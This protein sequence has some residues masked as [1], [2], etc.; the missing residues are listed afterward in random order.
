MHKNIG[1]K[2]SKIITINNGVDIEVLKNQSN[3]RTLLGNNMQLMK[4]VFYSLW[5][6]DG[7]HKKI[8]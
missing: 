2:S 7:A 6:Q 8:I 5:L 1:Y 4:P 3:L